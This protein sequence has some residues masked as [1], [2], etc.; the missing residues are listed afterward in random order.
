MVI[1]SENVVRAPPSIEEI[2]DSSDETP[3]GI[4]LE[5]TQTDDI[6]VEG[7]DTSGIQNPDGPVQL[8]EEQQPSQRSVRFETDLQYDMISEVEEDDFE[9]SSQVLFDDTADREMG[10]VLVDLASDYSDDEESDEEIASGNH[11]RRSYALRN[12]PHPNA[13]RKEIQQKGTHQPKTQ[14]LRSRNTR[15]QYER[16]S[17]TSQSRNLRST[18]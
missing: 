5:G 15:T 7:R 3:I 2:L 13:R 10:Q 16:K 12:R 6:Q 9:D 11:F 1:D 18:R 17:S 8:Q 14:Q 4:I